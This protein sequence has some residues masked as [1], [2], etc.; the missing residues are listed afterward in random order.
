[1]R[2]E[3]AGVPIDVICGYSSNERFLQEYA[4][5]SPPLF[6]V[7]PTASDLERTQAD[8]DRTADLNGGRRCIYPPDILE[9]YAIHSLL[10]ERLLDCSVLLMHGT[11][12]CIDGSAVL[13]LAPGGTGK[14]THAALWRKA[15]GDRVRMIND[16]KPLLRVAEG[17]V[18]VFGSP[19]NGKNR[20]GSNINAPLQAI[21]FLRRSEQNRVS[22]LEKAGAFPLVMKQTFVRKKPGMLPRVAALVHTVLDAADVYA[23]ACNTD[24]DAAVTAWRGM[25]GGAET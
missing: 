24:P 23:L 14:S 4:T 25:R 8:F 1:M 5:Q 18:T 16:D 21:A 10:A 6:S 17:R 11:A 7:H 9:R 22:P 2:I 20:L 19:W 3:L 13:F 12:L 15:F